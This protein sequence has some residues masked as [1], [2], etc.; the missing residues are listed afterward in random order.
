MNHITTQQSF[1]LGQLVITPQA[2]DCL[3]S[4]DV[5]LALGRHA[6]EDWG[7]CSKADAAENSLSV[8]EGFRIL[9]VY[10]DRMGTKFW[11]ITEADRSST[12]I[13][14]PEEY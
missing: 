4:E 2:Q 7:D 9:S 8:K 3:N 1:P 5:A 12:C 6:R 11:I 13:L 14:L 10:Q